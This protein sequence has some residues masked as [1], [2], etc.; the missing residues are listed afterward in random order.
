MKKI[1]EEIIYNNWFRKAIFKE[2][3]DDNL[4]KSN[5]LISWHIW[6]IEAVT[7]I[8]LL[9]NWNL[10]YIKEFRYWIEDYV[11]QFPMW[12]VDEWKTEEYTVLNELRE[13]V[14]YSSSDIKYIWETIVWN[15][16]INISK[17]YLAK[18]CIKT[19]EQDLW[20][21]EDI[22]FFETSIKEFENMILDWKVKCPLSI[23][24]FYFA[25]KYF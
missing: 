1:K 23:S 25:K 7:I 20:I 10:L 8:P 11:I 14:W 12:A 3:I 5:F 19:W 22:E 18:E 6:P 21:W 24:W 16:D 2:F 13:E 15:Y 9:K 4:H 17:C